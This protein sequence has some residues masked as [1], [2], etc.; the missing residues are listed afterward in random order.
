MWMR[1]LHGEHTHK[2]C[3]K[4]DRTTQAQRIHAFTNTRKQLAHAHTQA[5]TH[6]YI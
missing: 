1:A 5:H 6:S 2:S 4:V 3:S